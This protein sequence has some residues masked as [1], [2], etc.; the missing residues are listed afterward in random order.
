MVASQLRAGKLRLHRS[1]KGG[2][3]V[4]SVPKNDSD[5]LRE[6]WH[7]AKVSLAAARPPKPP[8]LASPTALLDLEASHAE[9]LRLSKRDARCL[10]DQ[11]R[12]GR[13]LEPWMGR[14]P[15]RVRELLEASDADRAE[16]ESYL[17]DGSRL[18]DHALVYPVSRVWPMGF[19]WSSFVAQSSMLAVCSK[20][21]LKPSTMLSVDLPTPRRM[22]E[23]FGLATDDVLLFTR[24]HRKDY[25]FT[26]RKLDASFDHM[27]I[28]RH[29]KKDVNG[30]LDGTAIGIDLD[31]GLRLTPHTPKWVTLLL[32]LVRLLTTG[33]VSPLGLAAV[34]G[35]VQW[36]D[37]LNRPLFSCLDAVYAFTRRT[38]PNTPQKLSD[39]HR[40][41]L[42]LV[43]LLAPLWEA[44]LTRDW[45]PGIVASDAAPEFG[46]G[47]CFAPTSQAYAR[48]I[49][50]LAT[51]ADFFVRLDRGDSDDEPEKRRVGTPD[52][53]R[54]RKTAFSTVVCAKARYQAH[55][56]ALEATGVSLM[57]Q[58]LLRSPS[59]HATR[60]PALVDAQAVLGAAAKGRSSAPSL[61]LEI[62]R[63]AALTLAG[64][65]L[66]RYIYVPS[67]DNPAD[68][69]SRGVIRPPRRKPGQTAES[70]LDA[71][72]A[73]RQVPLSWGRRGHR[74]G[75]RVQEL[76]AAKAMQALLARQ[77]APIAAETNA[78][79]DQLAL[80]PEFD[81]T[82]FDSL[83]LPQDA[84]AELWYLLAGRTP[85]TWP[86]LPAASR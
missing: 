75:Q 54:L 77:S 21:G 32:G 37:Q 31:G 38:H 23:T 56:G 65:F 49:G 30:V 17:R 11:L 72:A 78:H 71:A 51:K 24:G 29:D 79:L 42:L 4:F 35:N 84:T 85:S 70:P 62:R 13:H 64:D 7:G 69:P 16:L 25:R 66:M 47:V 46:F 82:Y 43:I 76:T 48:E 67:E 34:L 80:D 68:A 33:W 52:R 59:K 12:L 81:P 41:E 14:P 36:F 3:T 58:W 86:A 73:A 28:R 44:D 61:K 10:F 2:G 39:E 27:G 74:A 15:L 60:V 18:P 8:H 5:K 19:S 45:L 57:L 83:G 20:A 53:L 22:D 63:I 50:T 9:P 6:V 40:A 55:S 26:L 1:I